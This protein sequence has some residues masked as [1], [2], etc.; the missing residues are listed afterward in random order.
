MISLEGVGFTYREGTPFSRRVLTEVDLRIGGGERVG[1]M[2]TTGSGKTTLVQ[3]LNG[4]L[5]PTCGRVRVNGADLAARGTDLVQVRR[6]VGLLFQFPEHQLF[7]ETV[8]RDVGFGPR[9][10]GCSGEEVERRVKE[11]MERVGL[12]WS[13]F[14]DRNPFSLSGGEMRRA[15]LAGVMAMEPAVLVLDEPTA[16]M[17]ALGKRHLAGILQALCADRGTTLIV[18]S[19][20]VEMVVELVERL[21]VMHSGRIVADGPIDRVLR[22]ADVGRF[23]LDQPVGARVGA[24][25][26]ERGFPV[27][28]SAVKI[29]ALA[30]EVASIAMKM[31][32]GATVESGVAPPKIDDRNG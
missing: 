22:G 20:D 1:L 28:L 6:R 27:P 18:V 15:A 13:R 7:E 26:R 25:L 9:N 30:Q 16:G 19:H 29:S 32:A 31:R 12:P 17:D 24:S 8:A 3:L 21:L 11:A 14:R 2:G 23:G 10:L 4:L 5:H